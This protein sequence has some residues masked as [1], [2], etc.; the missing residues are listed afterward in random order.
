MDCAGDGK[1]NVEF[2][3]LT[4]KIITMIGF[5]TTKQKIPKNSKTQREIDGLILND[6]TLNYQVS[7]N[8]KYHSNYIPR[9]RL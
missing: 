1:K 8:V 4:R 7:S 9:W 6:I 5:N 2:E 3:E